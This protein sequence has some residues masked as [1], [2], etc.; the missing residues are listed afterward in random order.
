M[1][2]TLCPYS[3]SV[4][5]R[6]DLNQVKV[7]GEIGRRIDCTIHNN[8]QKINIADFVKPFQDKKAGDGFI[9]LGMFIDSLVRFSANSHDT[10]IIQL[11]DKVIRETLA[12][13][14]K[15]GYIGMLKPDSRMWK[16]WDIHEMVYLVNG[17][18]S[19]YRFF[20]KEESLQ[21][22]KKVMDFIIRQWKEN[23]DGLKDIDTTEFMA[24][25][26]LEEALLKLYEQTKDQTYLDFCINFRKLP[27]WDYP[28]DIGRWGKIGGHAF[29]YMH[30]CL[31][32][33]RLYQLNPDEKLLRQ[34]EGVIKFLTEEDGLLINGVCSQHECWHDSQ[35]GTEG[36]GETCATGYLIRLMDELIRMKHDSFY[37]DIMERT[38]Y[39]GLFAAQSPDGRK[40]RYYVPFEGE[41][42][43]FDLDTYC[44]PNNYRRIL[45]ELPSMIYY[46]MDGG[47]A[48][49]L[50]SDSETTFPLDDNTDIRIGQKTDYPNSGKIQITLAPS[51]AAKFPVFLRIPRWCESGTITINNEE[52]TV[53]TQGGQFQRLERT[54]KP[55]DQINLNLSIGP[56]AI[57][58]RKAQSGRLAFMWGPQ[59][60]CLNP[61]KN[62]AVAKLDI[63]Q[64]VVDPKTVESPVSDTTVRPDGMAL[65]VKGW[66]KLGF[67][68]GN[69]HDLELLLTE[70]PDPNGRATYLKDRKYG[71]NG[72]EDELVIKK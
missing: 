15:D 50:Y 4:E 42:V 44:C 17:L 53:A 34:T 68:T 13:Q 14:E 12:T 56:R 1:F 58:G 45:S 60:F 71:L 57:K 6:I 39:N 66:K 28:I 43:F 49:N 18:V 22:A 41:R 23:P 65:K 54:W 33:L 47:V 20:K 46:K 70:F 19:D 48:V 26:G 27:Q 10:E 24:V 9:G 52:T 21:S 11:K 16:L 72:I 64:I 62:P 61:D 59:L 31:A 55:G 2:I 8:V 29:A 32:Q 7:S 5:P 25:T 40:L 35:D 37:G 63:N 30:R 3:A 38:I 36:L 69:N 67:S 51:V